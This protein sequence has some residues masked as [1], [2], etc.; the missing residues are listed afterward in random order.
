MANEKIETRGRKKGVDTVNRSYRLTQDVLDMIDELVVIESERTG[1]DANATM[2][3][4][5]AIREMYQSRT[6][7]RE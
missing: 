4:K 1:L 7:G 5:K 6:E 2:I 3:V